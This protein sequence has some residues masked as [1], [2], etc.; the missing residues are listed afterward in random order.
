VSVLSRAS[1]PA[2]S[3]ELAN[4]VVALLSDTQR[5]APMKLPHEAVERSAQIHN[6]LIHTFVEEATILSQ[7]G[8]L[9]LRR[10]LANS[11][12]WLG[13]IANGTAD[14]ALSRLRHG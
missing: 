1:A 5:P 11:W 9:A 4:V 7:V 8:S 12:A 2:A 10:F 13:V 14:R 6:E 3:H